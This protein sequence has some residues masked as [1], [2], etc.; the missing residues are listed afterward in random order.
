MAVGRRMTLAELGCRICIFGPSSTGKSTLAMAI[1]RSRGLPV[2]H[3]DQLHHQPGTDW[4]PRPIEEFFAL[5][6]E[7]VAGASWVIEGN[8]SLCVS[9][10]LSRATGVILLDASATTSLCAICGARGSSVIGRGRSREGVTAS[11]G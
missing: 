7:A 1:G 5:H 2:V 10:R 4:Q 11:S 8:Y 3:L 9:Q 6:D